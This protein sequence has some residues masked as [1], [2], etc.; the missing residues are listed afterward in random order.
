MRCVCTV[1]TCRDHELI[2]SPSITT[3]PRPS[4]LCLLEATHTRM[5][6]GRFHT[7]GQYQVCQHVM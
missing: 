6:E 5:L 7:G 2:D 4:S 1:C 3:P